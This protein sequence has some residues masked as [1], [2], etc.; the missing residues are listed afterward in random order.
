MTGSMCAEC[1]FVCPCTALVF[2]I[3]MS[4]RK[5]HRKQ[6]TLAQ[7]RVVVMRHGMGSSD[8]H[9]PDRHPQMNQLM[10]HDQPKTIQD[11]QKWGRGGEQR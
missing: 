8:K 5:P 9:N 4:S 2:I 10:V 6:V 3:V 7:T 11:V 1:A